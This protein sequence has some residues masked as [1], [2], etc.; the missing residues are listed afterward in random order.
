MASVN[1][2]YSALK[3]L[4]N[5]DQRGF[6]TPA[7]FNNFAQVAQMN[8]FNK[9]F[10]DAALNKRLRQSQF[11][12]GRDK[13]RVKQANEDLSYFSKKATISLTSGIGDKPSD[14]A[15]IISIFTTDAT[16]KNLELIY[17]EEKLEYIL[18]ST[19][20][21]PTTTYPIALVADDINV[22][23]TSI[24]SVIMRYYKIPQGLVPSTGA[25]T[26]SSPRFGYTV[27]AGKEVYDVANSVDFELPEHYFAELVVEI[28]KLIGVNLRDTDVYAYAN[29]ESQQQ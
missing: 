13:S 5:K 8:L 12:A 19:L 9:L 15:R 25:R 17:D 11:D 24:A 29:Q 18:R 6:V 26:T 20:S 4:V 28:A 23:P 7:V 1:R 3:D 16:A 14:L 27:V 21:A 22:F 10:S 2:V